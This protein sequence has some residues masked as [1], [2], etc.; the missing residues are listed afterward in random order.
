[1]KK[2]ELK[3][4]F[5]VDVPTIKKARE[6][7]EKVADHVDVFKLGHEF[8]YSLGL[9]LAVEIAT[10][11]GQRIMV[12]SKLS[13]IPTTVAA[14]ATSIA[15][16]NVDYLNFAVGNCQK[17]ALVAAVNAIKVIEP[18]LKEKGIIVPEFIAVALMTS[19]N[20][21]DIIDHGIYLPPWWKFDKDPEVQLEN[22]VEMAEAE[23]GGIIKN[24]EGER[25]LRLRPEGEA[26]ENSFM[27]YVALKW[28]RVANEGG[29]KTLLS[30]PLEAPAFRRV[31][32]D[33]SFVS[34]GIRPPWAK[35]N[36]QKRTMTPYQAA[37]V[38]VDNL[39]VGRPIRDARD[40]AEAARRIRE[41]WEKGVVE[42]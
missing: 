30:S 27:T 41:D 33:C 40:P 35:K 11:F 15:W 31:F 19:W 38:W 16:K 13:D 8:T 18:E 14:G 12:D 26:E 23:V 21:D 42:M 24:W 9:P 3:I 4:F 7:M 10:E 22:I 17:S 28:A 39:V 6:I 1:M 32:P 34:P 37:Q 5:P 25:E 29:I 2:R 20:V 36:D